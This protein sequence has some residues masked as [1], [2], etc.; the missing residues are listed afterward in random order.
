MA[1]AGKP[2]LSG[3]VAFTYPAFVLYQ[4]AR[5]CIVLAT[6]MQAVAI[7]WQVYEITKQKLDLGLVALSQ[8]LPGVLLF[9]VSGYTADRFDRRRVLTIGYAA[10]AMCSGL[11]LAISIRGPH[12]AYPLYMVSVLVGIVRSSTRPPAARF[13]RCSFPR[14]TSA[15]PSRGARRSCRPRRFWGRRSAAS[16]TRCFAGRPLCMPGR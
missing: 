12:T 9:L 3:R 11:L 8:F 14:N 6:E 10:F 7:G 5:F 2:N 16:S 1:A 15:A 4:L 13:F